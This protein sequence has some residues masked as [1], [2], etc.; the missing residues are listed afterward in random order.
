MLPLVGYLYSWAPQKRDLQLCEEAERKQL[1][2][3]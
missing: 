3:I 2:E 1:L